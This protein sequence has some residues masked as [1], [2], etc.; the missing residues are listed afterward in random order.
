MKKL[1]ILWMILLTAVAW[2]CGPFFPVSYLTYEAPR[3][4][5]FNGRYDIRLLVKQYYPESSGFDFS[6]SGKISTKEATEKD[7][8]ENSYR[9]QYLEFDA[10][11]RKGIIP[12]SIPAVPA[13]LREFYLYS[14]GFAEMT[15][16][17][18]VYFPKYWKELLELPAGQRHYR[19]SWVYYMLGNLAVKRDADEAYGYYQKL[20]KAVSDD[21]FADSLGLGKRSYIVNFQDVTEP[22]KKLKYWAIAVANNDVA[23]AFGFGRLTREV[24]KGITVNEWKNNPF[25]LELYL[26]NSAL[27]GQ[28]LDSIAP[29]S[30]IYIAERMAAL[31]YFCN[32]IDVCRKFL[33]FV[34]D[35]SLMKLYLEARLAKRDGNIK[36]AAEKLAKWLEIYQK[37]D[38]TVFR[39]QGWLFEYE[40]GW[41]EDVR[42][43]FAQEVKGVLGTILVEQSDFLEAM[44]TFLE[45]G[46]WNDAA[47]VAEEYVKTADLI[48]YCTNHT[49]AGDRLRY[50]LARRLMREGKVT[51]AG[52]WFPEEAK[53]L[54]L[55][56]VDLSVSANDPAKK[57]EERALALF[58]LGQLLFSKGLQLRGT[59]TYP[60]N[61]IMGGMYQMPADNWRNGQINLSWT[62][63]IKPQVPARSTALRRFHYR[64]VASDMFARAALLAE[65]PKLRSSAL[66]A[67]GE[68]IR[69]RDPEGANKYYQMLCDSGEAPMAAAARKRHWFPLCAELSGLIRQEKS[70]KRLQLS[71]FEFMK[72]Y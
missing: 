56:Y 44:H 40:Q 23:D 50:L 6:K 15:G 55:L 16:K 45:A 9:P 18:G 24:C 29:D 12:D 25:F 7:F 67:A 53:E 11:C 61:F 10:A 48:E 58:E 34:P 35:D 20:R 39:P 31:Y 36:L 27:P 4:M 42:T 13:N 41:G 3:M 2:G 43:T 71:D 32:N 59:E 17:D 69:N 68:V 28:V 66:W 33:K 57:A 72:D 37:S 47:I 54:Y 5:D 1:V 21:G 22:G 49:K 26:M 60:D 19:T 51:E 14:A 8:G 65:N 52:Q 70:G 46:S 62:G 38:K 64:W 30:K 63:D